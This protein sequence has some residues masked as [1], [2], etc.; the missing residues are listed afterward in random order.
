[1]KDVKFQYLSK[2]IFWQ[3]LTEL[4]GAQGI[5]RCNLD[6]VPAAC[7][8]SP[9][10]H[11][12]VAHTLKHIHHCRWWRFPMYIYFIYPKPHRFVVSICSDNQ[13]MGAMASRI[14]D[15]SADC[16]AA[17]SRKH[18]KLEDKISILPAL[19][20]EN[21]PVT[22]GSPNKGPL[23]LK[24]YYFDRNY[25]EK[26]FL[27]N[28]TFFWWPILSL[29][30]RHKGHGGVSNHQLYDCLLNRL[31][32]KRWKRSKLRVT[33]LCEGNSLVT[34]EFPTQRA[35]NAENISIWWRHHVT[36]MHHW[37]SR[38]SLMFVNG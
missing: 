2:I 15:N 16:S 18:Y 23:M 36:H 8:I 5:Q 10:K 7:R 38:N 24:V 20:K 25:A 32:R 29:Q 12:Q 11:C 21:P 35:S 26:S 3:H 30:L 37:T 33:G 9:I 28:K 17:S 14:T 1:M 31:F 6:P 13:A 27:G 34:G 4:S 22:S 19:C